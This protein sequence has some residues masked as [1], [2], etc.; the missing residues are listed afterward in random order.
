MMRAYSFAPD[1]CSAAG[2][3]IGSGGVNAL[4][5][6]APRLRQHAPRF[7]TSRDLEVFARVLRAP[8]DQRGFQ[9][10]DRVI[11]LALAGPHLGHS[12][13][14]LRIFVGQ[15][16]DA[17]VVGGRIIEAHQ[18][19]FEAGARHSQV[20]AVGPNQQSPCR[21]FRSQRDIVRG[22]FGSAPAPSASDNRAATELIVL[23]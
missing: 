11:C 9:R 6:E 23:P 18:A 19:F 3:Q 20:N 22:W 15:L 2:Q 16:I 1:W 14:P 7:Q 13:H 17:L 4:L 8:I 12:F 5:R 21:N 10:S